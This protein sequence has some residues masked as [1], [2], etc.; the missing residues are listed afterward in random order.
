MIRESQRSDEG[1]KRQRSK[2]ET[3]S[4]GRRRSPEVP[5][6]SRYSEKNDRCSETSPY[7]YVR[8]LSVSPPPSYNYSYSLPDPVIHAPYPQHTPFNTLP[9]PF[10]DYSAQPQYH[11]LLPTLPSMASY[12]LGPS[13]H[14]GYLE[15]DMLGQYD[16]GY[17]P[18]A[19]IEL[20][21]QQAYQESNAHVNHPEYRFQFL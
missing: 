6:S 16:T 15:E 3:T 1:V 4:R 12:E 11:P 9:A 14:T 19:G 21:M 8:E 10:T 17:A 13:K 2:Q 18:F 5:L 20:P 7:Q